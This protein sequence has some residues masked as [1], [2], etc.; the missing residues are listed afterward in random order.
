GPALRDRLQ[1]HTGAHAHHCGA[2]LHQLPSVSI[3]DQ[4][5]A[6]CRGPRQPARYQDAFPSPVPLEHDAA[7]G[8]AGMGGKYVDQALDRLEGL[9]QPLGALQRDEYVVADPRASLLRT[10]L[11]VLVAA[12]LQ[13]QAFAASEYPR[14]RLDRSQQRLEAIG[15]NPCQHAAA[16]VAVRVQARKRADPDVLEVPVPQSTVLGEEADCGRIVAS[17]D[18]IEEVL[19]AHA[20]GNL[21]ALLQRSQD[22]PVQLPDLLPVLAP[23]LQDLIAAWHE[24]VGWQ[25]DVQRVSGRHGP[26]ADTPRLGLVRER[27]PTLEIEPGPCDAAQGVTHVLRPQ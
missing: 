3:A 2:P 7:T 22:V 20:E 24:E 18:E 17:L 14:I 13:E 27:L 19:V 5:R 4:D 8:L 26:A 25:V 16:E 21:A 6:H 11:A 12:M 23:H 9:L 15:S 10:Q 1:R